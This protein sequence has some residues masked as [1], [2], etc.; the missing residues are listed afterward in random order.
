MIFIYRTHN[1]LSTSRFDPD[2]V[3]SLSPDDIEM[4]D[5]ALQVV[6]NS[7]EYEKFQDSRVS[8]VDSIYAVLLYLTYDFDS[9]LIESFAVLRTQI[10]SS[11]LQRLVIVIVETF[12]SI[13]PDQDS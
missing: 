3:I 12:S 5:N 10:Y 2:S 7:R 4:T 6:A 11:Y 9:T 8:I 13:I 1:I